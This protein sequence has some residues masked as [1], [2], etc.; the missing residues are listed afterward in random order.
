[1]PLI[2]K[3]RSVQGHGLVWRDAQAGDAAFILS[4]RTDEKK[5]RY[6]SSVANDLQVQATWLEAYQQR[7]GEAYF[8]MASRDGQD[9]GTVRLYDAQGDSFC[10]GS[11]ILSDARPS[12]AA[13][14][15]AL[16]VYA[17]AQDTLGFRHSHFQ[18]HKH[19]ERVCAFHERFGAERVAQDEV[20][21]GYTLSEAH[22]RTARDRYAR[23]LPAPL[24]VEGLR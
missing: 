24:V 9:L 11:W 4:L 19:N 6:L 18:V 16:M 21:Y 23:F 5:N 12:S 10:W 22:I 1:M 3:A 2:R 14:E 7:H 15:S 20:E 13:M 8:I 17:Y